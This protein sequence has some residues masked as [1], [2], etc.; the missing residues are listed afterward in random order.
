MSNSVNPGAH[1]LR[2]QVGKP[3]EAP[4]G[5][6]KG[7]SPHTFIE[8][9]RAA[10]IAISNATS[11]PAPVQPAWKATL[12]RNRRTI[13]SVWIAV[14]NCRWACFCRRRI[15]AAVLAGRVSIWEAK[16][17][18]CWSCSQ[19]STM[20][21]TNRLSS[22]ANRRASLA[23]DLQRAF[24]SRA[25]GD[26]LLRL[27]VSDAVQGLAGLKEPRAVHAPGPCGLVAWAVRGFVGLDRG[28]AIV[29]FSIAKP[30]PRVK[31]S[32]ISARPLATN[33]GLT[34]ASVAVSCPPPRQPY[35]LH[36]TLTFGEHCPADGPT[37][38]MGRGGGT[39]CRRL[40]GRRATVADAPGGLRIAADQLSRGKRG[41]S[42]ASDVRED[43]IAERANA[44]GE[45][46][47]FD[48]Q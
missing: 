11:Y 16:P 19:H 32:G 47:F 6:D 2:R 15:R 22:E 28:A 23:G 36:Q 41:E 27:S 25:V 1:G 26:E 40:R 21:S 37:A 33:R 34:P 13:A 31:I 18:A 35:G 12:G 43:R 8:K 4:A 42:A 9:D 46:R 48:A 3:I 45:R 29:F 14:K 7:R 30:R 44:V 39:F 20:R 10:A 5:T 24:L 38:E 17:S